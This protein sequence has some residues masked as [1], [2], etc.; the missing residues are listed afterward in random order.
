[1]IAEADKSGYRTVRKC[2]GLTQLT[3]WTGSGVR[4]NILVN[5]NYAYYVTGTQLYRCDE[6]GVNAPLGVVGGS[7][8]AKLAANSIPGDSQIL[9]LNGKGQGFTYSNSSGLNAISDVDF[10][11]SSSVGVLDE[12]FWLVRNGTNEFFG[13]DISD[14]TTYNPLTFDVADESPDLVVAVMPKKSA[15]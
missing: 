14:G 7:G 4:S 3:A 6:A 2:D 10:F 13:S 12:R 8:R 1:M 5:D 15:L 9:V 11:P